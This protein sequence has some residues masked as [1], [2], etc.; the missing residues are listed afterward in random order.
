MG[1]FLC[2]LLPKRNS[3]RKCWNGLNTSCCHKRFGQNSP[4]NQRLFVPTENKLW[5]MRSPKSSETKRCFHE[6]LVGQIL[7]GSC[8]AGG[9]FQ[10]TLLTTN[11]PPSEKKKV[12]GNRTMLFFTSI[13]VV[14]GTLALQRNPKDSK[15]QNSPT[16]RD[17][18]S[19]APLL[20]IVSENLG[21]HPT[22]RWFKKWTKLYPRTLEVM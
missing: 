20:F 11:I 16:S 17:S 15:T 12:T 18:E 6:I 10:K 4:W 21:F 14:P 19:M 5:K 9:D 2:R 13:T 1:G 7:V 3:K 22:S 8:S